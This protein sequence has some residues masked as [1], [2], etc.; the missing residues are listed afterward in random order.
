MSM[1][2]HI[3]NSYRFGLFVAKEA[4][5]DLS[6]EQMVQQ[7]QPGMN[8]AAWILGHLCLERLFFSNVAPVN[9]AAPDGWKELFMPGSKPMAQV[10]K[11]PPKEVLLRELE[12]TQAAVEKA[13]LGMSDADLEKPTTNERMIKMFPTIGDMVV[14]LLT[15]HRSFHL[16]QLSAWRRAMGLPPVF[17]NP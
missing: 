12:A 15:G 10:G 8:H 13:F 14:G 11:Y 2:D 17:P 3:L 9:L 6:D 1:R 5:K 16:G 4:V 7:A